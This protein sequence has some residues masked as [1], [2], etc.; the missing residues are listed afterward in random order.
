LTDAIK[1]L[2][3]GDVVGSP[4]RRVVRKLVP[5]LRES[6]DLDM[7]VVN[8]ENAAG[9]SGLTPDIVRDFLDRGC[10]CLTTG[11][12]V[13]KNRAVLEIIDEESRL[14]RPA[15]I[16]AGAP[17]R[18]WTV[19]ELDDGPR[20][21][22]VNLLGRAFLGTAN[23][24]FECAERTLDELKD[25]ADLVLVDFHAE[26][27]AEKI[28]MGRFLDGRAAAVWGTH[29]HVQTA[30]EAVFPGGT[31]Y[32]TDL[33]MT[34][35]HDGVIGRRAKE[36][37]EHLRMDIPTRWEIAKGELRLSGAIFEIDVP[38]RRCTGVRRLHLDV[39]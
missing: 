36:V 27:T 10:D 18:G 19:I 28:A 35:G 30:D 15:N 20:V 11:D 1:V 8:G 38:A 25:I 6:E 29:T 13:Y 16:A 39:E 21:A 14:L 4:G 7:V 12:H 9:G 33:G 23:N 34:G 32:I 17:G 24:P 5:A 37:V 26:A 22:V 31:G 3:V 2:A